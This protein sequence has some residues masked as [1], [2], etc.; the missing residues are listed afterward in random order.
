M[1]N[2]SN[3]NKSKKIGIIV[4]ARMSSKRFPGKVLNTIINNQNL[5]E[6]IIESLKKNKNYKNIIISTSKNKIDDKI[7]NFCNR[8]NKGKSKTKSKK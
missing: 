8:I 7:E 4:Y 1:K 2:S 6:I 5:L 3:I